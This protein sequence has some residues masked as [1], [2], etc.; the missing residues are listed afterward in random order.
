MLMPIIKLP[1]L[2]WLVFWG[3]NACRKSVV[4]ADMVQAISEAATAEAAVKFNTKLAW[5]PFQPILMFKGSAFCLL[6]PHGYFVRIV[7][8]NHYSFPCRPPP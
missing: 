3:M 5:C 4:L 8:V 2:F 6:Q 7:A 1:W